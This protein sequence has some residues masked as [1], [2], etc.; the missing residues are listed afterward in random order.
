[1]PKEKWVKCERKAIAW[2]SVTRGVLEGGIICDSY[3]NCMKQLQEE[4]NPLGLRTGKMLLEIRH[5]KIEYNRI[6]RNKWKQGNIT[7]TEPSVMICI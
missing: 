3:V 4:L 6:G 2:C 7:P 5:L 1:M